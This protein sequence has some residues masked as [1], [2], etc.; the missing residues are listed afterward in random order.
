MRGGNK[1]TNI[2]CKK[3]LQ[4]RCVG[5]GGGKTTTSARHVKKKRDRNEEESTVKKGMKR[6]KHDQLLMEQSTEGRRMTRNLRFEGERGIKLSQARRRS[7]EQENTPRSSQL[8]TLLME[9]GKGEGEGMKQN[10]VP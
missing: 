10:A 6:I 7:W 2:K 1:R 9:I 5:G 8:K 3:G 4:N